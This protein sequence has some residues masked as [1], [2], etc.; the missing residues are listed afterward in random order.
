[1]GDF[2]TVSPGVNIAGNVHVGEGVFFG[3][4]ANV[5]NGVHSRPLV[6]GDGAVV[7]A[8]ACVTRDVEPNSMV[9]GVPAIRKR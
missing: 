8:G 7:A 6:I 9:A 4:G 1:V 3:V 5:I 2:S